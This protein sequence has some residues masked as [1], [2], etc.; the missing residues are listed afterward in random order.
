MMCA[1]ILVLTGHLKIQQQ[2]LTGSNLKH[3]WIKFF[4]NSFIF[5]ILT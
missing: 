2:Q 1:L 3:F 4:K 5:S